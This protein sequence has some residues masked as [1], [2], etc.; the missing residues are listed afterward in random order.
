MTE[1]IKEKTRLL[2]ELIQEF[3]GQSLKSAE[4]R[5]LLI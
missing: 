2:N 5:K 3:E 1:K 4:L